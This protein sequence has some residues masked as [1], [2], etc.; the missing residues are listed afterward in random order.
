MYWNFLGVGDK[1]LTV[2]RMW[3]PPWLSHLVI[4]MFCPEIGSSFGL[5]LAL[6]VSGCL[7]LDVLRLHCMMKSNSYKK[8]T[9]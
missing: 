2:W 9:N 3:V 8:K 6:E 5:K 4:C 1:T 7:V